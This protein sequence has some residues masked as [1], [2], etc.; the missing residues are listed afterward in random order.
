MNDCMFWPHLSKNNYLMLEF[1][2]QT[3]I[4]YH[5]FY[6]L[7]NYIC[8]IYAINTLRS[9]RFFNILPVSNLLFIF[10]A[11][12]CFNILKFNINIFLE[13]HSIHFRSLLP[14]NRTQS[15][16]TQ[17]KLLCFYVMAQLALG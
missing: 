16:Y 13:F 15:T 10:A 3:Y 5:K 8:L 14:P 12:D 17:I 7:S 6:L 1:H 4:T 9:Y 2:L 11:A